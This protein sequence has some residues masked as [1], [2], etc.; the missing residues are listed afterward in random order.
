MAADVQRTM[1]RVAVGDSFIRIIGKVI[2]DG[3]RNSFRVD[4]VIVAAFSPPRRKAR[5][6]LNPRD[7]LH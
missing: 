4:A 1:F 7:A 3:G 5:L 2:Y 6:M